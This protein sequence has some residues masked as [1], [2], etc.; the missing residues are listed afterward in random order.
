M[1]PMHPHLHRISKLT[2]HTCCLLDHW[3]FLATSFVRLLLMYIVLDGSSL[4]N[5]LPNVVHM[6]CSYGLFILVATNCY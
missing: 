2:I 4:V 6:F 1:L 5:I 3:H